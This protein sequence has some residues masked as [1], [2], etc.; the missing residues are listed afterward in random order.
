MK[1]PLT[2]E[3]GREREKERILSDR[4]QEDHCYQTESRERE[5]QKDESS[6]SNFILGCKACTGR[7]LQKSQREGESRDKLENS[8]PANLICGHCS[9]SFSTKLSLPVFVKILP[10]TE[11]WCIWHS[12]LD[13]TYVSASPEL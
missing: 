4:G 11:S 7:L 8:D 5:G 6:E 9:S 12:K 10:I 1:G 3:G 2:Q 13:P